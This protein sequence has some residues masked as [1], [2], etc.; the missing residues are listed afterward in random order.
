[1][2]R[3]RQKACMFARAIVVHATGRLERPDHLKLEFLIATDLR[4]TAERIVIQAQIRQ[5]PVDHLNM[6]GRAL[7]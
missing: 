6:N 3:Q 1:M 4:P 2:L 7:V 5:P